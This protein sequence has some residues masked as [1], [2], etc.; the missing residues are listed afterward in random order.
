MTPVEDALVP[1][2]LVR[3]R[4]LCLDDEDAVR[5]AQSAMAREDFEFAFDL[6]DDT[7]WRGYIA[8]HSRRQ[9][10]VGLPVGA[11]PASYLVAVSDGVIV[12]RSSI[13]HRLNDKLRIVGGHVGYCVLPQFRRRGFATEICRQSVSIARTF[14]VDRV[15]LTCDVE[16][17]AS[18][19]VIERC[20]GILDNDWPTTDTTPSKNR[21]WI[22]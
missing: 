20:G 16:N 6:A 15:L 19:T 1:E 7:D 14:G 18:K 2:S 22:R 8:E 11:V 5:T 21:Y 4:P 3:L 10:G 17:I 12:G 13:R 9:F